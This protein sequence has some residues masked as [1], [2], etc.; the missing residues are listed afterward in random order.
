M[1]Q[2]DIFDSTGNAYDPT[3]ETSRTL[4]RISTL[5]KNR[6]KF[7]V[8]NRR[9][10]RT[11]YLYFR[12]KKSR[13]GRSEQF[14]ARYRPNETENQLDRL[15]SELEQLVEN[16]WD[17]V[18]E[19]DDE[20]Y[21][22]I[23]QQRSTN[24]G[25]DADH[26]ILDRLVSQHQSPMVGVGSFE[27]AFG[28]L[29]TSYSRSDLSVA[30]ADGE[31]GSVSGWDLVVVTGRYSGITPLSG[32]ES[33]WSQAESEVEKQSIEAELNSIQES[34]RTL[35]GRY[36]LSN[37]EIRNRV[38]RRVPALKSPSSAGGVAGGRQSSSGGPLDN[39][40]VNLTTA[41]AVIFALFVIV[42]AAGLG[43]TFFFA[44]DGGGSNT[45]IVSGNVTDDATNETIPSAEITV[46]GESINSTEDVTTDE[47]GSYEMPLNES[48]F[49]GSD[50][51]EQNYTVTVDAEGYATDDETVA[52]EED[53]ELNFSLV[54]SPEISG[55]IT[56]DSGEPIEGAS[57]ELSGE[58][59]TE[60]IDSDADGQYTFESLES[61]AYDISV[62]HEEYTFETNTQS[63]TVEDGDSATADF[64]A[65][66]QESTEDF[67]ETTIEVLND[68]SDEPISDAEVKVFESNGATTVDDG[69]T[70]ADG[71]AVFTIEPE[72][73]YVIEATAEGYQDGERTLEIRDRTETR[74]ISLEPE[75]TSSE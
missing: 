73:E 3:A 30:I 61:G 43:Y 1:G 42:G 75:Q 27:A 13:R 25:D 5:F 47:N 46:S 7:A 28:L 15:I 57:V 17:H 32:T 31:P 53:Q 59:T 12:A 19:T 4:D 10:T 11:M 70:D 22:T 26:R 67:P 52:L 54:P 68:S 60:E 65:E 40:P 33:A 34:V 37:R 35:S 21:Q 62:S 71:E 45:I 24:P 14:Y 55:E 38:H 39:L 16:K 64:Q 58:G 8:E 49:N 74:T 2:I 20:L 18:I 69:E 41:A 51:S 48:F 6:I 56:D 72:R 9:G 36:G 63:V 66:A 23:S 44:G 50:R 29:K